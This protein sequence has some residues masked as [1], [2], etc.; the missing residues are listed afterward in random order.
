MSAP[1]RKM[2]PLARIVALTLLAAVTAALAYVGLAFR[3]VP[4]SAPPGAAA[5]EL[6]LEPC[7]YD[8]ESGPMA[9]DCGTLVVPENHADPHSRLIALP[10]TRIHARSEQ[11]GEPIFWFE[12]GPGSTNMEFDQANRL[13]EEHDVVLVGY[14]GIDGSVRLDCPEVE[15]ALR[16]AEDLLGEEFFRAYADAFGRCADRL[17][18]EGVD[19]TQYGLVQ[20]VDDMEVARAA[21]G[22]DRIDLLSQSAGTRTAM[23]YAWRYP[24]SI[25]RSVMIAVNPPGHLLYDV[26]MTDELVDRLAAYCAKDAPCRARTADLA[27]TIRQT[28]ADIPDRWG[29]LPL[30]GGAVRALSF[31]GMTQPD[32]ALPPGRDATLEGWLAAAEGDPSGFWLISLLGKTMYPKFFVWGQYAAA[33]TLDTVAARKYFASTD[34]DYSNLGYAASASS[35]GEARWLDLWPTTAEEDQYRQ[36]RTSAVPTL[37]INGEL[38][39]ATPPQAATTELLPSLPN[40]Q[41]VVLLGFGHSPTFWADQPGAG[42]RL[43]T[44]F[45]DSG[46]V[47]DS[48]YQPQ[49]VDFT[50]STTLGQTA[51]SVLGVMLAI[52]V[53][54]IG[55]LV[56]AVR[57]TR[58]KGGFGPT[59]S[60]AMRSV[61]PIVL[62]LGGWFLA[63]LSLQ[64]ARLSV[65]LDSEPLVVLAVGSPIGLGIFLGWT[66]R[67][68]TAKIT[69]AGLAVAWAGALVGAW[70]GFNAVTAPFVGI[71]FAIVGAIAAANFALIALDIAVFRSEDR[72]GYETVG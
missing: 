25:H 3:N 51:K 15:A 11:P 72:Q 54:T 57:R 71:L 43:I 10:V 58:K 46:R 42:S 60:A 9:A 40:G 7:S 29:L 44:T 62:G 22:Y 68:R 18:D 8:T 39:M 63:V 28:A 5:G 32:S 70:L 27:E 21:L 49:Q 23:I 31:I 12:G 65:P 16:G 24:A 36:V 52:A 37:I 1:T 61:H 41:E 55:S 56:W 66:S 47:D 59:A 26:Q 2:M 34:R 48:L 69:Q 53:L 30:Q 50:P 14:R 38:D 6:T 20:Q 45:L 67:T 64:V 33:A 13:L 17:T 4:V 19:L 35:W